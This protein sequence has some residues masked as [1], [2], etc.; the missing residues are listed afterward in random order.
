M[1][2]LIA[3]LETTYGE[4]LPALYREFIYKSRYQKFNEKKSPPLPGWAEEMTYPLCF[5]PEVLVD[6]FKNK[7]V[8]GSSAEFQRFL[9]LACFLQ[10]DNPDQL[11]DLIDFLA[12]EKGQKCAVYLWDHE[13]AFRKLTNSLEEFLSLLK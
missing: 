12:F 9:P 3:M 5:D 7:Q 6:V 10:S 13:G 4:P 11:S 8:W 2:D 1:D